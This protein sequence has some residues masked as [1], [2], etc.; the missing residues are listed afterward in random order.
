MSAG[1]NKDYDFA[2]ERVLDAKGH[3][4]P[5]LQFAHA[6]LCGVERKA[7]VAINFDANLDLATER[8]ALDLAVAISKYPA[9][10]SLAG[11]PLKFSRLI[12]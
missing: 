6:R 7:G 10:L 2:W 4:G 5:Y 3:T 9:A 8:E 1:R 12:E 11:E